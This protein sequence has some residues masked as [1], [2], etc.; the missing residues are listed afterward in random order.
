MQLCTSGM[1]SL[2]ANQVCK[3]CAL[4]LVGVHARYA[5]PFGL[6]GLGGHLPYRSPL[7]Q[8]PAG[9]LGGPV[10]KPKFLQLPDF[11]PAKFFL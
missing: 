5:K 7:F 3:A 10:H 4:C 1:Q 8:V 9:G 6:T 11:F 2:Y